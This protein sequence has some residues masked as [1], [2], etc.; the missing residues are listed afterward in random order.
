MDEGRNISR[1]RVNAFLRCANKRLWS[2]HEVPLGIN[3]AVFMGTYNWLVVLLTGY[4]IY[5]AF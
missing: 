4:G 3:L 2:L 1:G 5:M